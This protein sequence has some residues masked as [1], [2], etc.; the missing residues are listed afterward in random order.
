MGEARQWTERRGETGSGWR[1]WG[2]IF[3]EYDVSGIAA[4]DDEKSLR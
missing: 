1:E 3:I 4:A 2:E